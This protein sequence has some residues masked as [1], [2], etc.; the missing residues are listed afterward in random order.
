MRGAAAMTTASGRVH[1]EPDDEVPPLPRQ[2]VPRVAEREVPELPEEEP[3]A[4][5][6]DETVE[7]PEP[8]LP[9]VGTLCPRE[10][11]D[12]GV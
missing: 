11:E 1:H 2:Q 8:S 10:I 7:P 4:V 3:P 5:P 12:R 6:E 9:P